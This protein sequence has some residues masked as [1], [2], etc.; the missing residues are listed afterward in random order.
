MKRFTFVAFGVG[1][2]FAFVMPML[3]LMF[4]GFEAVQRVLVPGLLL[5]PAELT[6]AM[7]AWPGIVNLLVAGVA[8]GAVYAATAAMVALAAR[9][10]RRVRSVSP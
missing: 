6:D 3:A 8:N 7:A 4:V 9:T 5:M 2:V 1:F 10:L